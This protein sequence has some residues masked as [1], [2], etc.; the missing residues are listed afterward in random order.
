MTMAAMATATATAAAATR[1]S[2]V[3]IPGALAKRVA[4]TAHGMNQPRLLIDLELAPQVADVH[5]EGVGAGPEVVA[6]DL[7]EDLGTAEHHPG[8]AHE[9]LEKTE[10]GAGQLELAGAAPD[11][12]RLQVHDHVAELEGAF[13]R[14]GQGPPEQR[15]EAGQKLIER[16]WLDQ[17]VV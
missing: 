14:C 3:R 4:N 5:L 11:L 10:L 15:S 16:E 8:I 1:V 13:T 7:L 17:V 2:L 9:Q 12:H 6:P